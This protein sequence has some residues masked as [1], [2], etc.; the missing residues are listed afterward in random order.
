[1]ARAGQ[2]GL[3]PFTALPRGLGHAH[4]R[5]RWEPVMHLFRQDERVNDL[6]CFYLDFELKAKLVPRTT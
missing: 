5:M 3:S 2:G 4:G 1:M 6:Y